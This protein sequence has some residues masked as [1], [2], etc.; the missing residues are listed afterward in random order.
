[1]NVNLIVKYMNLMTNFQQQSH[2]LQIHVVLSKEQEHNYLIEGLW[3][4]ICWWNWKHALI[5]MVINLIPNTTIQKDIAF[6]SEALTAGKR[7]SHPLE[8]KG[9]QVDPYSPNSDP[10][11]PKLGLLS[12]S[13]KIWHCSNTREYTHVHVAWYRLSMFWFLGRLWRWETGQWWDD[14]TCIIREKSSLK[15]KQC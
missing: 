8:N 3:Y 4:M 7:W 14:Y 6:Q 10:T 1:M 2:W 15:K 11:W 5:W 13:G 12:L 9:E